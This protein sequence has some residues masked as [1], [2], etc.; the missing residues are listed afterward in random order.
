MLSELRLYTVCRY[1]FIDLDWKKA[2][3]TIFIIVRAKIF[4][5]T[6]FLGIVESPVALWMLFQQL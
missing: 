6:L 3:P 1:G 2:R 5:F 4:D